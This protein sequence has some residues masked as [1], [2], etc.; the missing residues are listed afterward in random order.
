VIGVAKVRERLGSSR[1]SMK[2]DKN[3]HKNRGGGVVEDTWPEQQSSGHGCLSRRSC[4]SRH[5]VSFASSF[6]SVLDLPPSGRPSSWLV[7]W[8]P[9]FL[10][11]IHIGLGSSCGKTPLPVVR[12]WVWS[13]SNFIQRKKG[14]RD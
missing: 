6:S 1:V 11:G 4:P 14:W 9:T 7:R 10:A 13:L 12:R 8:C 5:G 2:N 3:S